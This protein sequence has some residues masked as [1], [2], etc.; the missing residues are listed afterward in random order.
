MIY[1]NPVI[2]EPYVNLIHSRD[3]ASTNETLELL[4]NETLTKIILNM[5]LLR[6]FCRALLLVIRLSIV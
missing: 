3:G 1:C 4:L 5:P 2:L 6:V